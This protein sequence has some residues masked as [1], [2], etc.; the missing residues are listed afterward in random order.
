M[1]GGTERD[2]GRE[3][4]L[5]VVYVALVSYYHVGPSL[6]KMAHHSAMAGHD[7]HVLFSLNVALAVSLNCCD[8]FVSFFNENATRRGEPV[9]LKKFLGRQSFNLGYATSIDSHQR[10]LGYAEFLTTKRAMKKDL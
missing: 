5:S 7:T 1:G 2:E 3:Q 9:D 10:Q 6:Q 4:S 8:N